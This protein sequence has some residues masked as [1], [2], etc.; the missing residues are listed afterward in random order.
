MTVDKF[1][2]ALGATLHK[3][4]EADTS[5][6]PQYMFFYASMSAVA[7]RLTALD[8]LAE[9][10]PKACV[11]ANTDLGKRREQNQ[12]LFDF[13]SNA[14]A[15]FESFCC[16]SYF[17]GA[18]LDPVLFH[19]GTP[20]HSTLKKLKGI[21]PKSTLESYMAFA[22]DSAFTNQ[23][24]DCLGSDEYRLSDAMR[25]LLV[26][27]FVPGRSI[28]LSTHRRNIPD[29]IDLDLWYKGDVSRIYGGTFP[30]PPWEFDLDAN[31]LVRQR[32]WIDNTIDGLA[33]QLTELTLASLTV[34]K[35][36]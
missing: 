25:N 36:N 1:M 31:C 13:F 30:E 18:A 9:K 5:L 28:R 27:R 32:D 35:S 34:P 26:H 20:V 10:F 33:K 11:G 16:G 15:S 7:V 22:P 23:L 6:K 8:S 17:V 12:I 29:G 24:A 4:Q 19:F 21:Y 2:S 14:L 3:R